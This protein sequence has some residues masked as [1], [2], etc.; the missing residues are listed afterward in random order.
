MKT[1]KSFK[2]KAIILA[3]L[4][5]GFTFI[6][7]CSKDDNS[8]AALDKTKLSALITSS[9]AT[10]N[11]SVEGSAQDQY[12]IGS[13]ASLQTSISLATTV[14]NSST[15]TQVQID[16]AVIA[17]NQAVI[18]FG[19][20]K[21]VPID[22]ANLV[23]QWTFD[24]GTG[25]TAKDYSGNNRNGTFG[26]A[27]AGLGGATAGVVGNAM[28]TWTTDRY[29]NVNK[30]IAFD[31]GAKITIPYS[32]ALN[33]QKMSLSLWVNAAEKKAGNRMIGLH[34]WV[35]FKFELQDGNLPFFTANTSGGTYDRDDAGTALDVNKWYHLV[36]TIGD[37]KNT[38]YINGVSVKSWDNT[39][40]TLM[41]VTGHDLVF[42]VDSSQ[43]AATT[44]NFDTDKIIPAEWGGFFHGSLD[45]VRM[46]KSVLTDS[47]AKS[48]YDA[49]KAP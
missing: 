4:I 40:G 42:G 38:F 23:G 43:Y 16:N 32:S 27:M 12:I 25:T 39:P 10:A 9:T 46:Y 36:V 34:S 33:P 44:T 29:G 26:S 1:T 21:I 11:A 3:F 17:L 19:T 22:A 14:L 41:A 8:A 37:G 28:P 47:Q 6:Q 2:S 49:E 7:S 31:K 15:S 45:E 48:I 18:L 20:Q 35:G 13:I 24:E 30:A 5:S